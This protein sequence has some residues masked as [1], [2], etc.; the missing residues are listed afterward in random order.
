MNLHSKIFEMARKTIIWERREYLQ[1]PVVS[2]ERAN[3]RLRW[4]QGCSCSFLLFLRED[5]LA[6]EM[7]VTSL[8]FLSPI[9][10]VYDY[11]TV[12]N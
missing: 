2:E 1:W 4:N 9:M 7:S 12:V 5:A 3:V 8:F 11:I 6:H 10:I